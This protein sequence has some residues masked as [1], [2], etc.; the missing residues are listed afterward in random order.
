VALR[1]LPR[2][3]RADLRA[4]YAVVRTLDD[5]GDEAAG[6][7]TAR[8]Q[9]FRADLAAVW[10]TGRPRSPVLAGLVPTVQRR[11]LAPEPFELLVEANLR[12]Q[13]VT[14]YGRF[15]DLLDYCALSAAPVGRLVLAVFG[16]QTPERVALSDRVCAGLQIVEHLQDVAEDRRRGRVYLPRED[17]AAHGVTETDL[18]APVASAALRAV[19]AEELSR[20][21]RLLAAGDPLVASLSGWARLAVAGYVA[22]GRAAVDGVQRIGHDVLGRRPGVRRRDL[23]GHLLRTG[24]ARRTS[25]TGATGATA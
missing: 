16:L 21:T 5:L 19:I 18:D 2:G 17:L 10:S 12:D 24:T 1:V 6:D 25:P 22:G 13:H 15:D 14:R 8:L 20:V 23:L 7:R 3:M 4:V 9:D 11:G